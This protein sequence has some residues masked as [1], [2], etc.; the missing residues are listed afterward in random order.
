VRRQNFKIVSS[1]GLEWLESGS[2]ARQPWLL[3]AFSTRLGGA[4][5]PPAAGLNLGFIETDHRATV[6]RNR[7]RFYRE[8]RADHFKLAEVQQ[9]HSVINYRV[10]RGSR[11]ELGYC[12]SGYRT[13]QPLTKVSW[14]GDALLTN[15]P[16]VLLSVRA[17]DCMPLLLADP[18]RRAVAAIHAGWRGALAGI[19]EITVGE[20]LRVFGSRPQDLLAA[21]GPSIRACC[22]QVG[23]DVVNAF[24]GRYANG[25][26][27]FR[28][29]PRDNAEDEIARR[30]RLLFLTRQ[31]PG[32]GPAVVPAIHLD[33]VAV[34]RDQ[35]DRAGLRSRNIQVAD[36]CTA[37]RTDLFF[38][39]RK[40]GSGTGRMM[41]VIG[42][43]SE[44]EAA[45][46]RERRWRGKL[47]ATTMPGSTGR[48][49]P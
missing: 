18:P 43:R 24:C 38:S 23:E 44:V 1:H 30:H 45:R 14:A 11:G 9:I 16:G 47:A 21:L 42:I 6:T 28:A 17:A 19:V 26:D 48:T 7:K 3:H 25:E 46:G 2:L 20:M 15:E 41:A 4:S 36:F 49:R 27:F 40:E 31:P 12:P 35:L 5:R 39:H 37:C 33:L 10:V 32:H 13:P 29:T 34:A 8:L 22:Y